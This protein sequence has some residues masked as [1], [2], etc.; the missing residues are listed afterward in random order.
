MQALYAKMKIKLLTI[1]ALLL[2]PFAYALEISNPPPVDILLLPHAKVFEGKPEK[3]A[4]GLKEHCYIVG[5]IYVVYSENL[6]GEGYSFSKEKPN[7]QC[8]ISKSKINL[9][10]KL[11]LSVGTTQD[12]ASTLLGIKLTE[13][14]NT[15]TWLYQRPIHNLPYDDMTTLNI[16]IKNGLVYAVSVFNTV[17]S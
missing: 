9:S 16:I 12:K 3:G 7:Q 6:L 13:G 4:H 14:V 5:D 8:L 2:S 1:T 11:G 15:I 17:T 10:N